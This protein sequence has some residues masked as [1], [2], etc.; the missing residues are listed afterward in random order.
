MS[1]REHRDNGQF[2]PKDTRTCKRC[3][4]EKNKF[5]EFCSPTADICNA[6]SPD[7]RFVRRMRALG[8]TQGMGALKEK[9]NDYRRLAKLTEE[10]MAGIPTL[11]KGDH[12]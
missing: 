9:L 12:N 8:K 4:R 6:C 7:D 10:A 5:T 3:K 2:A 11:T 1:E